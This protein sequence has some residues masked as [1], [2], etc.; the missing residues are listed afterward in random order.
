MCDNS[1]TKLDPVRQASNKLL[2]QTPFPFPPPTRPHPPTHHAPNAHVLDGVI[3]LGFDRGIVGGAK[4]SAA[5]RDQPRLRLVQP[6]R[7]LRQ[8]V[9]NHLPGVCV[10]HR[11]GK[12]VSALIDAFRG[13]HCNITTHT[14]ANVNKRIQH[15]VAWR[16][17]IHNHTRVTYTADT[18]THTAHST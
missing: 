16:S 3:D 4:V 5:E 10:Q 17:Y 1:C 13:L 14:S 8:I 2:H 9:L 7:S 11:Q 15:S 18:A 12:E 6:V